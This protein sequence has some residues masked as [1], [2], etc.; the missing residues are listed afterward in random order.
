[1]AGAGE[2]IAG[3]ARAVREFLNKPLPPSDVHPERGLSLPVPAETQE[4]VRAWMSQGRIIQ[5]VK[6]VRDA[7]GYDLKDSRDVAHA[8]FHGYA[9]PTTSTDG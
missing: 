1:M 8:I 6:E 9:V 5:A 4:R 2:A 3:A 7:T